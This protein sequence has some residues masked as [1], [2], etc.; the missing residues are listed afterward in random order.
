MVMVVVDNNTWY[1]DARFKSNLD[2]YLNN[3]EDNDDLVFVLD[4]PEGAGKSLRARQIGK[5]CADKLGTKFSDE[6]IHFQLQEYL[7]FSLESPEYTVCV[8]DEARNVLNKKSSNSKINKKFTNY[9]SECR[10]KRQVHILCI[11]AF[12]DLDKYIVLWRM[13]FVVHIIKS[14]EKDSSKWSGYALK[15][16][17]FKL[18]M[19]DDYLKDSYGYPYRY[20]KRYESYGQFSDVEVFSKKEIKLYDEKKDSNMFEKYHSTSEE[21]QLNKREKMWKTRWCKLVTGIITDTK[22]KYEDIGQYC[23]MD[24]TTVRT[25]LVQSQK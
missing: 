5:Y 21:E 15:R 14:I 22:L 2:I 6:N 16:G 10:K 11:P 20:P 4:G 24:T 12:H 25:N 9:I 3:M 8:L 13:K 19:N 1:E 23:A 17:T 18:F 7:D